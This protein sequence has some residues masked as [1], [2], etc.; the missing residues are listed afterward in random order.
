MPKLLMFQLVVPF[1][2]VP[3]YININKELLNAGID[4]I[5]AYSFKGRTIAGHASVGPLQE[6]KCINLELKKVAGKAEY[7]KGLSKIIR[8]H[9]PEIV[10]TDASPRFLT[11]WSLQQQKK[12]YGYKL[13]G[14][15]CGHFR[16]QN[17]FIEKIRKRFFHGFDGMIAYHRKAMES[18]K[19]RYDLSSVVAVGN[20]IDEQEIYNEIKSY[21]KKEIDQLKNNLLEKRELLVLFVGKLTKAKRV[22]VLIKAAARAPRYQFIIIGSGPEE[23][24]LKK[25]ASD[26][27]NVKFLGRIEKGVNKYFQAADVFVLPGLGGLALV[28]ALHNGL[29]IITSPADGIGYDAVVNRVNGF[30]S[31]YPDPRFILNSLKELENPIIRANFCKRSKAIA[32]QFTIDDVAKRV[33]EFVKKYM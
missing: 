12:R 7:L 14:W 24:T 11:A 10:I 8:E 23:N 4:M 18:F 2:R 31:D 19:A 25:Q 1:W 32:K 9:R 3:L 21:S 5:L 13:L 17:V 30:I 22:D 16:N 28:Q 20:A 15:S 29:P 6:I 33:V 27:Q 26:L